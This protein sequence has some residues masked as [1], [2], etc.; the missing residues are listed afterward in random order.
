MT[1]KDD[2]A[3]VGDPPMM[4]PDADEVHVSVTFTWDLKKAR[5][6]AEAWAQYYP[7]V[8]IGGPVLESPTNGFIPGQY[9]K[10]G[11]TFTSRGCNNK[12][13]WCLVPER[14]GRLEE[15]SEFP[16]GYIIQDN[17]LLQC[18]KGHIALVCQMLRGQHGIDFT[19]GLDSR[20]ITDSIAEDLRGLRIRQLFL[21]CDTKGAVRPLRKAVQKLWGLSRDKLRC[22]VLLAFNNE[23][24]SQATEQLE[25]VWEVGCMPFAQL[26]QPPDRYIKYP[27]EWR[28]LAR[29][30]SRPAI[31]KAIH[32]SNPMEASESP[33]ESGVRFR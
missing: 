21:A 30:W 9:I 12:C 13:P 27:K 6:L 15:L 33:G 10:R 23:T 19:G 20:L 17:N 1:P 8:K 29:V 4:R 32:K 16:P 2:Y 25:Q 7:T 24:I 11:A 5:R 28:D 14:E 18:N 31:M 3:F 26:Y 22:Y